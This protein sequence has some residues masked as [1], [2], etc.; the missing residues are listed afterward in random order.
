MSSTTE[1]L[2]RVASLLPRRV[3]QP[4]ASSPAGPV[5]R[6]WPWS[7]VAL[8][9]TL[10]ADLWTPET[11]IGH[12]AGY[13]SL[14]ATGALT[15]AVLATGVIHRESRT[16]AGV[17]QAVALLSL[18]FASSLTASL[19]QSDE[20]AAVDA[21]RAA[22]VLASVAAAYDLGPTPRSRSVLIAA[23]LA[24]GAAALVMTDGVAVPHVVVPLV[25]GIAIAAR[26]HE[27]T[28]GA[29][30]LAVAIGGGELVIAAASD[31]IEWALA[32]QGALALFAGLWV[33][34]A[35]VDSY[36]RMVLARE[37]DLRRFDSLRRERERRERLRLLDSEE[38]QH[39]ARAAVLAVRSAAQLLGRATPES[40]ELRAA[41][42]E[43]VDA[44]VQRLQRLYD[45]E[46]SDL[47]PVDVAEVAAQVI[48]L[49]QALGLDAVGR[50]PEGLTVVAD[51]GD[52]ADIL[53]SLL[54]NARRHGGGLTIVGARQ[55]HSEVH[56][57]V[58]DQGPGVPIDELDAVFERGR[59]GSSAEGPGSGFGLYRARSLARSMGGE[60]WAEPRAV[61]ARFVLRLPTAET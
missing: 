31:P 27:R 50:I 7:L 34:L 56:V 46:R 22:I 51:H 57:E 61:G 16:A 11:H 10:L 26:W 2:E 52:L 36:R 1:V 48:A 47:G 32:R 35:L 9:A 59:R 45:G 53:R 13:V 30:V 39:D 25:A 15:A 55:R 8:A 54:D 43:A 12:L 20:I 18:A 14:A 40:P 41:L 3:E 60:L 37:A 19:L 17:S 49:Q 21:R 29:I 44:E 6:W 38:R 5:R 24:I 28:R 58:V 23:A 42:A 33:L 4:E